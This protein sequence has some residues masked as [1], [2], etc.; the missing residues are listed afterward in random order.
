MSR[1]VD[2]KANRDGFPKAGE[3]IEWRPQKELS[4]QDRRVFNLLVENAGPLVAEDVW[5]EIPMGKLRPPR[6]ESN[7]SVADSIRQ[8]MTTVVEFS[9]DY[10]NDLPA[11]Q[12]TVL[13][14]EN[15]RTIKED[16]PRSI[17]RY[18]FTETLRIIVVHSH[19]WGR[20]KAHI[21]FAFS[22]KYSMALYE[23]VCLRI[24]LNVNEQVFS[25]DEFRHLLDVLNTKLERFPD[26]YRYAVKAAVHE[27]NALSDFVV[28]VEPLREGGRQRGKLKGFRLSWRR[29][30]AAEWG[31]V[32]DELTR[33]KAGRRA[34][35]AGTAGRV[36]F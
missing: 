2:Q 25:V 34:R 7:S 21:L 19:Y 35:I 20:L 17:L 16:D 9:A 32:L 27:V 18:K 11:V 33:S 24:N 5:H 29:K 36:A 10:L 22:S 12:S 15:I 6:K 23:A 13:L 28:A 8:L 4:L 1:V 3:L 31:A 26:F 14:S 30:S